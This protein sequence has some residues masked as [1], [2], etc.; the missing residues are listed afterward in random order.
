MRGCATLQTG[1]SYVDNMTGLGAT[2]G[3][4]FQYNFKSDIFIR[5]RAYASQYALLHFMPEDYPYT[6]WNSGVTIGVRLQVHSP[7]Q[8][9]L[10]G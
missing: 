8:V 1:S 6:L 9:Q 5:I 3:A 2:L 10:S 7:G 4:G